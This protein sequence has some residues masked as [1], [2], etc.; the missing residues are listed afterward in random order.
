MSL[1]QVMHRATLVKSF[2]RLSQSQNSNVLATPPQSANPYPATVV[3]TAPLESS[4]TL[5]QGYAVTNS[6]VCLSYLQHICLH[7]MLSH[8]TQ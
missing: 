6:H 7:T 1:M 4:L 8:H 2:T 3:H 5:S